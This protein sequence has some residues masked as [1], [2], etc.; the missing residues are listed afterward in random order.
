MVGFETGHP[1]K[2]TE[3][4]IQDQNDLHPIE[5]MPNKRIHDLVR[6]IGDLN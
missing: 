4:M 1:G 6:L 3:N 5:Q 2:R